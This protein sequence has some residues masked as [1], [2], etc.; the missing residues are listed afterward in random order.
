MFRKGDIVYT[1]M[2]SKD[3]T[4]HMPITDYSTLSNTCSGLFYMT[5]LG[6]IVPSKVRLTMALSICGPPHFQSYKEAMNNE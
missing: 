6:K 4:Y 3:T 5:Q 1:N 2:G